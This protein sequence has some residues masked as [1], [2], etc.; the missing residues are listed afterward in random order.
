MDTIISLNGFACIIK[1]FAQY[2]LYSNEIFILLI[3]LFNTLNTIL[4]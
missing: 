4:Y 3:A 2:E 1:Y